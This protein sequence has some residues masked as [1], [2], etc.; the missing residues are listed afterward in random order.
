MPWEWLLR[1]LPR[2]LPSTWARLKDLAL[3]KFDRWG[4]R[5]AFEATINSSN[6]AS[7]NIKEG[8][9]VEGGV[10]R[11]GD[12][13]HVRQRRTRCLPLGHTVVMISP[14]R[15]VPID[16]CGRENAVNVRS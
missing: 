16:V 14:N 7:I 15:A 9:E 1:S 2:S 3:E 6:S 5:N 12:V 10:N 11:D 13:L 4:R 8:D